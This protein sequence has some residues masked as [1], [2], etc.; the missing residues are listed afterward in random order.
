[1]GG[2]LENKQWAEAQ[3]LTEVNFNVGKSHR[4]R[5]LLLLL[6]EDKFIILFVIAGLCGGTFPRCLHLKTG[7]V[8]QGM[9]LTAAW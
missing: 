7:R 2:F 8:M 1:M 4:N 3:W 9:Y 5:Y 6:D